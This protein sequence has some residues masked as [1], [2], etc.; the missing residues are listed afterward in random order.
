MIRLKKN[1]VYPWQVLRHQI[2]QLG[3][4]FRSIE[5]IFINIHRKGY[6]GDGESASGTGSNLSNTTVLIT[7]LNRLVKDYHITTVLDLPCG[8]FNWMKHV[9]LTAIN[10]QGGDIVPDIVRR[11]QSRY[12]HFR[13]DIMNIVDDRLPITDLIICRDCF[14]HLSDQ[15]VMQ[16]IEN[17]R[18]S[19]CRYLLTTTFPRKRNKAIVTG[20]WRPINLNAPP[21]NFPSA[22]ALI[23]EEFNDPSGVYNDKSIGL[24][25]VDQLPA[26]SVK[27]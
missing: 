20:S 5:S 25:R 3:N 26:F 7:A 14:V 24:W 9:D 16:A 1:L 18:R 21:F 2:F 15:H 10:Y 23:C 13:F 27:G 11:N 12:P 4:R 22:L 19:G 8:D 17:I 6:W